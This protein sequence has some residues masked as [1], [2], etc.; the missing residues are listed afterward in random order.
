MTY[1][2]NKLAWGAAAIGLVA[3]LAWG[4]ASTSAPKVAATTGEEGR[5]AFISDAV[6]PPSYDVFTHSL[7]LAEQQQ[8][9]QF[10]RNSKGGYFLF[11]ANSW[12]HFTIADAENAC[13]YDIRVTKQHIIQQLGG[14]IQTILDLDVAKGACGLAPENLNTEV[15]DHLQHVEGAVITARLS[16]YLRGGTRFLTDL[17]FLQTTLQAPFQLSPP[18]SRGFEPYFA[19]KLERIDNAS[20]IAYGDIVVY[21]KQIGEHAVGTYVGYGVVATCCCFHTE[22]QR[23]S[24]KIDYHVYRLYSGFAQVNYKVHYDAILHRLLAN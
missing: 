4:C 24:T 19:D 22:M 17:S 20:D 1:Y 5:A 11:A 13:I 15:L 21:S 3:L 18:P 9:V 14:S 23:L 16:E 2:S 12:N 6:A 7:E 8:H 10:R